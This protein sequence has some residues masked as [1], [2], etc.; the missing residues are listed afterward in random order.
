MSLLLLIRIRGIDMAKVSDLMQL[1]LFREIKVVAGWQGLERKVEYVTVMEVPDIKRWLK[2]NDFL[3]TSFYSVRNSE[4]KQCD[5]I[6]ELSDTCCCIAIKT[7]QYVERVTPLV[8][9]AADECG[10]PLLV[11]P[12]HLSY[13]DLIIPIMNMIFEEK[14][15]SVVIEKYVKDIIYENY[16]DQILMVERGQMFGFEVEDHC[17]TA[18]NI[19]FRKKF[20]P[21]EQEQKALR[22]ACKNLSQYFRAN[23]EIHACYQI[24]L[25]KGFLLL[26][27]SSDE[28]A[29]EAFISRSDSEILKEISCR[30]K[31]EQISVG[32]GPVG[33]GLKDIRNSYSLAFKAIHVGSKLYPGQNIHY[34]NRLKIFCTLENLLT[35]TEGDFFTEILAGIKNQELLDTLIC[36]YEYE[37]NMDEVAAVMYTH[38]NTAKYRLKRVQE[39]TGLDL[40]KP[41]DNLKLYLAVLALR[42]RA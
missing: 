2:G 31:L 3:I 37:G 17:F 16:G 5:L 36:Y 15:S 24:A 12:Y 38:K 11:I 42:M 27:E 40:K 33:K 6:R 19:C 18:V 34:Y 25:K 39:L 21:G 9:A 41:D 23:H 8:K 32:V 10:L 4:E 28:T 29:L 20:I 13:I 14:C 1:P 26:L 30:L 35:K 7:G 22:F